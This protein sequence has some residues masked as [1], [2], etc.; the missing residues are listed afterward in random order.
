MNVFFEFASTTINDNLSV[1]S[2]KCLSSGLSA[3]EIHCNFFWSITRSIKIVI[4]PIFFLLLCMYVCKKLWA[5]VK[6]LV[7]CVAIEIIQHQSVL[8]IE[9]KL[10]ILFFCA[11]IKYL[12]FPLVL[13]GINSRKMTSPLNGLTSTKCPE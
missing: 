11:V 13:Q 1:S 7:I 3:T 2:W 9:L 10:A 5:Y 6:F 4:F 12:I 8:E